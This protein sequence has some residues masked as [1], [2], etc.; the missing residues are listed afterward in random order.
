MRMRKNGSINRIFLLLFLSHKS[1]EVF[2]KA[3]FIVCQLMPITL[4][5]IAHK[6]QMVRISIDVLHG[7]VIDG[8]DP[9]EPKLRRL[10]HDWEP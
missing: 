10:Y 6:V 4:E 9:E 2:T 8:P 5:E 3:E 7:S 1:G